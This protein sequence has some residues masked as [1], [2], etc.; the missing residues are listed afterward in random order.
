MAT[1]PNGF[2]QAFGKYRLLRKLA[3]GGMA[4]LF[5]ATELEGRRPLVIK[6]VL[7]HFTQEPDFLKMF[8]NEA[9]I[10]AYLN[11]PGIA[12]VFDLGKEGEHLY[13]A[14][15]F[16]DGFDLETLAKHCAGRLPPAVAARI[17]AEVCDALYYANRAT[18]LAGKPLNVIHRDVTPGNVMVTRAGEVKLVDFG[19]AKAAAQLERT[20][21]G[22]VKGKFRYMSPEQ[23]SLKELDGRTDLF[24]LGVTIYEVTTG[25]RPFDRKQ[26][27]DIIRAL[28]DWNP[29]PPAEIIKGYPKP[30]SAVIVRALE[31]DREKR[32]RS[33]KEMQAAFEQ[34]IAKTPTGK[35]ELAAFV[36]DLMRTHPK[37]LQPV[38]PE[39][40]KDPIHPP[41]PQPTTEPVRPAGNTLARQEVVDQETS[42]VRNV[43]LAAVP[44]AGQGAAEERVGM[45]TEAIP[46]K[47]VKRMIA[48]A[49]RRAAAKPPPPSEGR[50][51]GR[52]SRLPFSVGPP[53]DQEAT[54][55]AL[56]DDDEDEETTTDPVARGIKSLARTGPMVVDRAALAS[57]DDMSSLTGPTANGKSPGP[58]DRPAVENSD[59]SEKSDKSKLRR[60]VSAPIPV[61]TADL[62]DDDDLEAP[63]V[64]NVKGVSADDD[65]SL[66]GQTLDER[67]NV[68]S[69]SAAS[70]ASEASVTDARARGKSFLVVV[71]L[72]G[73]LA[74]I[75]G[76]FV[77]VITR[78]PDIPEQLR[79]GVKL[80][81][82]PLDKPGKDLATRPDASSAASAEGH[83][84]GGAR[85]TEGRGKLAVDGTPGTK[86]SIDDGPFDEVPLRLELPPGHH[87]CEVLLKGKKKS[88]PC[89][90]KV[91]VEPGKTL[92]IH[93]P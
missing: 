68:S 11:H 36:A 73:A 51:A 70:G 12:Q 72:L 33:G 82:K 39:F 17:A 13:I 30:I 10:A 46:G 9:R 44:G 80:G 90:E 38:A 55:M 8:L 25:E 71:L 66:L 24:S 26:I 20:R 41:N 93:V 45:R 87:S 16:V 56:G 48:E 4:E 47:E 31:K 86:V 91:S 58:G 43:P 14:M 1:P 32:Y 37:E 61:P 74:L 40:D 85:P 62:G 75:A 7:P 15:D 64:S 49:D 50:S 18:D 21:P 76:W 78:T 52:P 77:Y 6:R 35:A 67:S 53:A 28:S 88:S 59:K 22:V 5:L 60:R 27:V 57:A 54:K 79:D 23:I 29:P 2:P 92:S 19:V 83:D 89:K 65:E 34:A 63:T 81:A 42:R 69:V 84:G 3:R